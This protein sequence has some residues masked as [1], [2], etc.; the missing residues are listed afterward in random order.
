MTRVRYV[1]AIHKL[2]TLLLPVLVREMLVV[3]LLLLN[4]CPQRHPRRDGA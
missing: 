1:E 3:T 4:R 2:I